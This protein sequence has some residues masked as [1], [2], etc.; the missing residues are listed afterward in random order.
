MQVAEFGSEAEGRRRSAS[1][2]H[3]MQKKH[4]DRALTVRDSRAQIRAAQFAKRE[5]VGR[6]LVSRIGKKRRRVDERKIVR[7]EP[8]KMSELAD[9][10]NAVGR[11]Q[12][13]G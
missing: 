10:F 3:L 7:R 11:A 13:F 2:R 8:S 5:E 1:E 9:G 4:L 6:H 12:Q